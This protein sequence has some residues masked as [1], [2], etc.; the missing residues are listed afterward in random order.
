MDANQ[1]LDPEGRT[2]YLA[3]LQPPPGY[4]LDAAV[5]T[6]FSLDFETALTVPVSLALFATEKRDD[7]LQRPLALLEG[8]ERLSDRLVIFA[9]AG[10]IQAGEQRYPRLCSL[11][12][13]MIV[14]VSAPKGG[15]FHPKIWALRFQPQVEG[16]PARLRLLILSR[17]LTRDRSWDMA[18]V[19]DG[20]EGK[21]NSSKNRPL[22]DLLRQLPESPIPTIPVPEEAKALVERVAASLHRADWDLPGRFEDCAFH[23]NGLG[24]AVWKPE[25]C[26]KLGVVSPFV[27]DRALAMLA[28][29]PADGRP[30]LLGRADELAALKSETLGRYA[31]VSVLDDSATTEDGEDSHFAGLEGLHAKVF[32]CERGWDV[33][34]TVGSGN[35]TSPAL[36]T[37]ANVEVFA[38][39]TGKKSKIGSVEDLLGEKGLG[40]ITQPYLPGETQTQDAAEKAAE[41]RLDQQRDGLCRAGMRLRCERTGEDSRGESAWRLWLQPSAPLPL[42]E[43]ATLRIWPI[44]RGSGHARDV[45]EPLREGSPVL[46]GTMPL[47]DLTRFM[48]FELVDE[49]TGKTLLFSTGLILEGLPAERHAAILRTLIDNQESFLRYLRLLL[50]DLGAAFGLPI[51]I[52]DGSGTGSWSATQ[53]DMPILEELVRAFCRDEGQIHDVDRLIRRLDAMEDDSTNPIPEEFRALWMTFRTALETGAPLHGD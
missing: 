20:S 43:L 4:I 33:S 51:A 17:N 48:A 30:V 32:V 3:N 53:D 27:D 49:A 31:R 45:L 41:R 44:T 38:T 6:T 25:S 11:L 10:R 14:E 5:A 36:I 1:P 24:K 37:G 15:A 40:R 23:V 18:L 42:Q 35:A 39:L 29:L 8:A 9:Q 46:L 22:V 47:V 50:A 19:L 34:L 21:R 12:E 7:L 16:N 52:Q 13:R 26:Q 2:L 28:D